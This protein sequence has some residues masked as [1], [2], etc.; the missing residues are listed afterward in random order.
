MQN[1]SKY[2]I[3][4]LN[5]SIVLHVPMSYLE[6]LTEILPNYYYEVINETSLADKMLI[7]IQLLIIKNN[8]GEYFLI[9]NESSTG[10]RWINQVDMQI[11]YNMRLQT[12]ESNVKN[13]YVTSTWLDEDNFLLQYYLFTG[14]IHFNQI[15]VWVT[16][17]I[18]QVNDFREWYNKNN[19]DGTFNNTKE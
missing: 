15:S 5:D 11:Y 13:I 12:L 2:F 19:F 14:E 1:I 16:G 3:P 18:N 4:E 17:I 8:A 7:S 9:V 10:D 6:A